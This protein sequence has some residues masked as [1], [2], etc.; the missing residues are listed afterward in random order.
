MRYWET[1]HTLAD[2]PPVEQD[3]AQIWRSAHKIVYS[4]TLETVSS[5]R[6]R[7]ERDFDPEAIRQMKPRAERDISVGGPDLAA[8]A[9]EELDVAVVS[10]EEALRQYARDVAENIA[11]GAL[12]PLEGAGRLRDLV[13]ALDYPEGLR[14]WGDFDEDLYL[15]DFDRGE[16]IYAEDMIIEIEPH[17]R[18]GPGRALQQPTRAA[19]S[20]AR[21]RYLSLHPSWML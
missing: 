17:R 7:I 20:E 6:T 19:T 3:Y 9:L 10:R 8:Q 14:S 21:A 11:A 15:I 13:R 5:A 18:S 16:L 4:R 12:G 2:Q 1:A